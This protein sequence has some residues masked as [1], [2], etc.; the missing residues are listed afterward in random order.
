MGKTAGLRP[1][2]PSL[3]RLYNSS[4]GWMSPRSAA[5]QAA[6]GIYRHWYPRSTFVYFVRD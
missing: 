3:L 2:Q 1:L 5:R 6:R 4:A